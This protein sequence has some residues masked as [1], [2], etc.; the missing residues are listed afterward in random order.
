[1]NTQKKHKVLYEGKFLKLFYHQGWEFVKRNDCTGI[2]VIAAMT[3]AKKMIFV[4][5]YRV[6]LG[7]NVVELPAGLAGDT[8][9]VRKETL[10]A[11]AKRELLEE[12]GYRAGKIERMIEGPISSGMSS[13]QI[14]FFRASKLKK[15]SK[16]GGDETENILVHEI[17]LPR[18]EAWLKKMQRAGKLIDPKVFVG[19]YFLQTDSFQD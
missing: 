8:K 14:T 15:I 11:A 4:E 2:A 18:V 9:S 16:G 10:A 5:Q 19:L 1:M 13:Q 12:T 17:P 7:Q 3:D 6:P